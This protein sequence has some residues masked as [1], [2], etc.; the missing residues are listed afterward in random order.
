MSAANLYTPSTLNDWDA[1]SRASAEVILPIV[2]G[3]IGR[4]ASV[5]DIGCSIGTWL[6]VCGALGVTD[7]LGTDGDYVDRAALRIPTD[8]FLAWDLAQPLRIDRRFDLAMSVEVAEHLPPGRSESL[9]AEL[10]GA[11][12]VVLFSAAIPFS[13]GTGH[14]NEQWPGYWAG[15]F[16]EHGYTPV[17]CI[18]SRVWQDERVAWWY[19]Q[20]I[21]IYVSDE[22]ATAHGLRD[23]HGFGQCL[24]LIH[25]YL[26][27]SYAHGHYQQFR[28]QVLGRFPRIRAAAA[29]V[30]GQRKMPSWD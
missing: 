13:G 4:P 21:F 20:N 30:G 27:R 5:F 23:Q 29:R 3:L 14:I 26:Y 9:V 12:P 7:R 8:Q 25:P 28:R 10:C 24:P 1:P 17:D 11:A 16:A 15:L 22:A 6:S 2:F 19:A 18:R